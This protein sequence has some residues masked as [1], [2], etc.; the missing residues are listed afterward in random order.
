VWGKN[1]SVKRQKDA[2]EI[3]QLLWAT[4]WEIGVAWGREKGAK[5]SQRRIIF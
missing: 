2:E 1:G 3:E 5:Q 4:L